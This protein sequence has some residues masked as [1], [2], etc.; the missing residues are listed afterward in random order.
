MTDSLPSFSTLSSRLVELRDGLSIAVTEQGDVDAAGGKGVLLLHG[1]DGPATVAGLATA[2]ADRTYVI[3]PTHPGF[4]GQP[5]PDW[6]DDPTDLA[7]AYLD[8][9]DTLR[10][11]DVVVIASSLGGWIATQM[12]LH[13]TRGRLGRLVLINA[14]GIDTDGRAKTVDIRE[15][16]PAEIGPLAFHDPTLLPDPA[17][18]SEEQLVTAAAN[19][20]AL[21]IYGGERFN[22]DPKL[23]RRLHR[24][25]LPALVLWGEEDGVLPTA[26]GRL[27]ADSIPNAHFRTVAKA[28][29]LPHLEQPD[30]TLAAIEE[31]LGDKAA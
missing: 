14:V 31:F 9:L 20:V 25:T 26:Y 22:H 3:T 24:V 21:E 18:L 19:R 15:L 7:L 2:L 10:L 30:L 23:R 27:Y 13:D 11:R 12:A 1:G 8:L 29:H 17:T 16:S 4:D 5:R 6:F 28:G